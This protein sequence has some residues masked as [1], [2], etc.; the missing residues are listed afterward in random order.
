MW[1]HCPNVSI[2][3]VHLNFIETHPL[4][5]NAKR[6]D[7]TFFNSFGKNI[8]PDCSGK[9]PYNINIPIKNKT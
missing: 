3:Q 6:L 1:L 5:P 7:Y 8:P 9:N 4:P 2:H